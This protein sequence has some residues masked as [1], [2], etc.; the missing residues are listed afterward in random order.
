MYNTEDDQVLIDLLQHKA[1]CGDGR[2]IGL[3]IQ[4]GGIRGAFPAGVAAYMISIGLN[5]SFDVVYAAS[6][7]CN[8]GL[9][10]LDGRYK[11]GLACY[12][13]D[14]N[15]FKFFRPWN[16][17]KMMNLDMIEELNTKNGLDIRKVKN[18]KTL[19][20]LFVTNLDNGR[21]EYFTNHQDIDLHQA[22]AASSAYPGLYPPVKLDGSYYID[23]NIATILPIDKAIEDR[24]TDIVVLTTVPRNHVAMKPPVYMQFVRDFLGRKACDEIKK[25]RKNRVDIYN[26]SLDIAFGKEVPDPKIHM[27]TI[28]PDYKI[29]NLETNAAVIKDYADHGW[30]KAKEAFESVLL[31]D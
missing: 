12:W 18:S 23:G 24:C 31:L 1:G 13:N 17:K 10:F 7:G 30:T 5:D 8:T 21:V 22:M 19:L 2:K 26:H 9:W 3:V 4:G 6:S 27:F 14:L 28:C 16:F 20:K 15:G 25:L 11:E 29:K